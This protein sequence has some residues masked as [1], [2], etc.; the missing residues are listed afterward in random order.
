MK[1]SSNEF[2]FAVATL[3]IFA[4]GLWRGVYGLWREDGLWSYYLTYPTNKKKKQDFQPQKFFL[5]IN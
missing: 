1:I 3:I 5:K 4:D 2:D